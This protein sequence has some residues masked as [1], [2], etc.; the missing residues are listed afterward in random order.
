MFTSSAD[1]SGLLQGGESLQ[2][3]SVVHKAYIEVNEEGTV[4]A[5]ATGVGVTT[6]AVQ[7]PQQFFANHPFIY[8]IW[9]RNQHGILFIGRFQKPE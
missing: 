2:V 6:T 5:G 1:L 3:S 9:E 8:W 4:A 7:I